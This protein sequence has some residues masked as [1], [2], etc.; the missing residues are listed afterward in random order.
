MRDQRR[1][2]SRRSWLFAGA[3]GLAI[4]AL[5]A[6]GGSP[7]MAQAKKTAELKLGF[8]AALSG[9]GMGWGMGMLGGL[10]LAAED[11]NKKGGLT[12]GDT[13]Y[14]L[15]VI[16]YDDKYAGPAAAQAAQ[17]LVSQ[18]EVKYIFGPLGSVSMLAIADITEGAK[19]MV[20]SNTYTSKALNPQKP[21]TFRLTPT[22]VET[23]GPMVAHIAKTYPNAKSVAV[24]GPNDE[25][26]KEV[27]SHSE[28]H[29]TKAGIKLVAK[30][31]YERGT[32]D[33]VP[34]LTKIL[35]NKPDIID[36]DGS[37]PADSGVIIKQARQIGYK[38]QIVKV[39]GPGV[40]E[41][42]KI[43]GN[44]AAEGL[45]YYSPW[46]PSSAPIKELMTR[47]EAKYKIPMNPL[48]IFFYEGGHMLFEAMLKA[49]SIDVDVLRKHLEAQTE[50]K[51]VQ[52]RYVWGGQA[53]Y[54][55]RHQWIAPFY[56][57]QIKNGAE[58]MQAKIDP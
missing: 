35:A 25:S 9:G 27:Q 45:M 49:N 29:Y 47:F 18:D 19:A 31:F 22:T 53:E 1:L 43:A 36:L 15:K 58:V 56:V 30:E 21:Y 55:I 17:R 33:Y 3:S 10:E 28:P 39:G 13:T 6:V 23:S 7:A 50:Y 14:T 54:G 12:I 5:A 42:I 52:G 16:A 41:S 20:L 11:I 26:G 34:I 51:G 38:G 32:Q 8:I 46:D 24:I 57:G 4:A 48:G 40:I 37:P 2:F 44:E